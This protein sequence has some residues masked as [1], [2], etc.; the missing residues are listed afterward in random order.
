MKEILKTLKTAFLSGWTPAEKA[1]ILLN[2]FLTGVLLGWLTAPL[3]KIMI[4]TECDIEN[5]EDE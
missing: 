1:L 2:V 4:N 3:K 5:E